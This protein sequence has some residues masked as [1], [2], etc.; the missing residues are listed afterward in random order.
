LSYCKKIP[1]IFSILIIA[2]TAFA[3]TSSSALKPLSTK[4]VEVLIKESHFNHEF[5]ILAKPEVVKEINTI[6]LTR[7][8]RFAMQTALT[9]MKQYDA[10]LQAALK[11]YKI[12]KELLA[13][14]IIETGYKSSERKGAWRPAGIWQMVPGTARRFGLI[15]NAQH[16]G[17]LDIKLSTAASFKYL[18]KMHAQFNNWM[19]AVL[20]YQYGEKKIHALVKKA[21]TKDVW[22][23]A[24]SS[25]AP[26]NF[27]HMLSLF[28]ADVIVMSNPAILSSQ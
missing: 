22:V 4:Q 15:V 1:V 10:I 27:M 9:R 14:P 3:N 6:I 18:N 16:D 23:L 21:G 26:K 28:Q 5:Q 12:P 2:L 24:H 20:A 7:Y 13:I 17:R 11:T 25:S 8:R 19:L